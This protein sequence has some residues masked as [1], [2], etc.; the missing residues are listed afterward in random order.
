MPTDALFRPL[1]VGP[2]ALSHRVVMA[3][4]TRKR[5]TVPGNVPNALNA[6]YYRQRATGGGLIVAEASQV[7]PEGQG[8]AATPGIHSAEQ[9][10][11]WRGVVRAIHER[12]GHVFLQLWHVGRLSHSS[13]QPGG[14]APVSAS[15]VPAAGTTATAQGEPVPFETPRA[16]RTDEIPGVVD[17]YARAARNA[18]L[19]GFDGVEVHAANGYLIEQFLQSRT[20]RRT[21]AYG[22][23]IPNRCRFALEV[24]RAVVRAVGAERVG[25]R[26]SPFGIAND[27][28]E[29]EPMP[30]YG[31]LVAELDAMGLAYL[32]LIEPRA[33]GAGK[34][35]VDHQGLPSAAE[36]F[37]PAW[38]GVLITAGNFRGDDA[39][40]AIERGHAD[41]IA[42]GRLFIS[43]PDLPRR[44]REGA[45]LAPYD[46]ATFY[47]P[48]ERGYTDYPALDGD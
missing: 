39:A 36:L 33:S 45:P 2:L 35:E 25:I 12:G 3:P 32:H 40:Q 16:L 41:A 28:G 10:E 11:G 9:V 13:L 48:G 29:T 22:G 18:M 27:S 34:A 42:F 4:L 5:A 24:V 20:N 46:R 7:M 6:A 17:A 30:L 31:H 1:R 8:T 26:L 23:S 21:D 44:L 43:N 37:R 38:R 47:T 19:A 14:G 15:A